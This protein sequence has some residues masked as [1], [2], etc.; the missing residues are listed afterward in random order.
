MDFITI[1]EANKSNLDSQF[2][3][4]QE[5]FMSP[6]AWGDTYFGTREEW[7]A[8]ISIQEAEAKGTI[9]YDW[10]ES[11][12]REAINQMT[13]AEAKT[14]IVASRLGWK[15]YRET[16]LSELIPVTIA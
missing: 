9:F 10:H 2:A 4:E 14:L 6:E 3:I 16:L 8:F 5:V 15:S 13:P 7:E 12:N 11:W 1:S